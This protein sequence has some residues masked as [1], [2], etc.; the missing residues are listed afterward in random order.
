MEE[1]QSL[2]SRLI[3]HV[4]NCCCSGVPPADC[5]LV[6]LVEVLSD[7]SQKASDLVVIA[8]I[9]NIKR[10]ARNICWR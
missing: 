9:L 10:G 6:F 8:D 7:C 4:D 3:G 5:K 1:G 2:H